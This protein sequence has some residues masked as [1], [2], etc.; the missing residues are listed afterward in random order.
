[1]ASKNKPQPADDA[2][3]E[4]GATPPKSIVRE[5]AETIIVCVLIVVFAQGFV[6][7]RSKVPTGS[8]LNTLLIGD[9]I[10]INRFLYAAPGEA[11]HGWLGQRAI[12]RGDV[13]VFQ[14][15][16]RPEVDLVKRVVGMPGETLELAAGRL[17]VDGQPL[18][19]PYL[20]AR[21][22]EQRANWG[23]STIPDDHYFMMGD[24]RDFSRDSRSWGPVP[25]SKIKG[26]AFFIWY[27]YKEE[28]NDHKNTGLARLKS[29]AKKVPRLVTHTRWK[30]LFSRIR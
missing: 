1:M 19:E 18:D 12:E 8:M 30:R 11:A 21:G 23:P 22:N 17:Y 16:E 7:M 29:M 20:R 4:N 26:R 15:V 27:S 24:N 13:I 28:P 10:L 9:Y 2:A 6:V 5:Y 3:P 14:S 25:R